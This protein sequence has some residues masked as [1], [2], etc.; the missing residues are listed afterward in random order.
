MKYTYDR[1][2]LK[3]WLLDN[4][5]DLL[6]SQTFQA[7]I[8]EVKVA[9]DANNIFV[10]MAGHDEIGKLGRI[11][12]KFTNYVMKG[13]M[14]RVNGAGDNKRNGFDFIRIIDGVNKRIF[15]I[16]HDVYYSRAGFYG[17]EFRWSSSY[18][19]TDKVQLNNTNL[20]LEYEITEN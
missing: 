1:E 19:E 5:D 20:L 2:D 18:N 11:E 8:V 10:N 6:E 15:Q 4:I 14:M 16:P 9:E 17:N 7:L 3:I 12:T 13:H